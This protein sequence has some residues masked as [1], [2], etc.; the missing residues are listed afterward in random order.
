M[1]PKESTMDFSWLLPYA[2]QVKQKVLDLSTL[3][4]LRSSA[5][6][7]M[8]Q[9]SILWQ[10]Q[11]IEQRKYISEIILFLRISIIQISSWYIVHD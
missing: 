8:L 2:T 7:G 1:L 11:L 9:F 4:E 5:V 6:A 3:K 10:R